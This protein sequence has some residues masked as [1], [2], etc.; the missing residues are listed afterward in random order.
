MIEEKI[1]KLVD[2]DN[3]LKGEKYNLNYVNLKKIIYLN[4]KNRIYKFDVKSESTDKIYNVDITTQE[5]NVILTYC[6]CPQFEKSN[7][8]KHVAAVLI[9]EQN[10]IF[11]ISNKVKKDLSDVILNNIL[12]KINIKKQQLNLELE[13]NFKKS[14]YESGLYVKFKIGI[15]KL[16]SATSKAKYFFEIFNENRGYYEFG[17]DFEYKPDE[18]YFCDEDKKIISFLGN[19]YYRYVKERYYQGE[20]YIPNNLEE[21]FIKL[22]KNKNYNIM[23]MGNFT[24]YK[25]EFPFETE[26]TNVLDKYI[27]KFNFDKQ[28]NFLSKK[29]LII[30]HNVY[31]LKDEY[32]AIIDEFAQNDLTELDFSK[33]KLALFSETI[34]PIVK[35]NLKIDET[36]KDDFTLTTPNVKLY[37]DIENELLT[38]NVILIYKDAEINYFDKANIIRNREYEQNIIKDL[39]SKNFKIDNKIFIDSL[40]EIAQFLETDLFYFSNKYEVFTTKKLD[41]TNIIKKNK[42]ES[43]FS[44]GQD[45]IMNYSFNIEGID[46]NELDNIFLNLKEKKRYYKLKNGNILNLENNK[47]LNELQNLMEDLDLNTNN[48]KETGTIPKYRAIYLD[49]LKEN[50]YSIIKTNNLFDSFVNN[51]KKFKNKKPYISE[52]DK[53]ILR[54]Y[55]IIGV[56]WLYNIYKCNLGGILAD[57]MG[58]GKSLQ[59][60]CF[61][62]SILKE[63]NDAKI[64]IV[65]PTSLIYNW[66]KEFDKFASDLNYIVIAENKNKRMEILQ[67]LESNIIITTYGLLRRDKEFYEKLEFEV[68]IIDEAQNIKNPKAGITTSSKEIKANCKIALTGTPVE[69]SVIELWSIFDFIMPGFFTNLMKFQSIYNIKDFSDEKINILNKLNLQIS[70]FILRRKKIDVA[71]DLPEKIENNIYF[72]MY[73]EQKKIYLAQL[74][75]TKEEMDEIISTEG[76]LKSRFK[77]LQLLTKLRQI[78]IDPKIIFNDYKGGSVKIDELVNL[79]KKIISNNHK[80]LLFTSF[81]TALNIVKE[82]FDENN[83]TSY[84]IDGSVSS[85]KRMELVEKF[86]ND[87]TNVFLIMLKA[88][89]TGLNLTSADVVIH[90]D[91][92]WNPQV[93]NQATDRAHRI[94][95]TKNVEVIKLVCNGTI[96]ERIIELQNK[97]KILSDSLIEGNNRDK[98]NIEKLSEK[99]IKNLLNY[100][101]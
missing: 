40:N 8:C 14:Y 80:I 73:P 2:T 9:K 55:Q 29:L 68:M 90:L 41:E 50:K 17:K 48:I 94:G 97:K 88:G 60:I 15:N 39:T 92:W 4:K 12:N 46:L 38:C 87:N 21:E 25:E 7:K 76:F 85:K 47:E 32:K 34:L 28:Y 56:K 30:D 45:N 37:F 42:I 18:Q 70:P 59:T 5:D 23:S 53:K 31:L 64:L 33:N 1:V 98:N 65:S 100:E 20:I 79:V 99:D 74:K 43:Q 91:L 51:F 24:G 101:E 26:I 86:N 78:C 10:K 19:C 44:I 52:E 82:K 6:S 96:E 16:Y 75:K 11:E 3:Y 58:L 69:N 72:D 61:I 22:L 77:I 63:K 36:I 35:D 95:Q 62:K 57:E 67:N 83:I 89:G 81:K 71:K 54:D 66:E 27:F 49:S 84:A 93:E 13:L